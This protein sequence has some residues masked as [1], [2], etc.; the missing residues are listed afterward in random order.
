MV[1]YFIDLFVHQCLRITE[2]HMSCKCCLSVVLSSMA[3]KVHSTSKCEDVHTVYV[4]N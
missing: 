3:W 1:R 4:V 2:Q